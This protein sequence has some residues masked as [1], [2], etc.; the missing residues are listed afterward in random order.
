MRNAPS[1]AFAIAKTVVGTQRLFRQLNLMMK[2]TFR[3]MISMEHLLRC[4]KMVSF[5]ILLEMDMMLQLDIRKSDMDGHISMLTAHQ[6]TKQKES[7]IFTVLVSAAQNP[8]K[9]KQRKNI[10]SQTL[11]RTTAIS[12]QALICQICQSL[13]RMRP[14]EKP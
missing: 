5:Y 9:T 3:M 8:L 11:S 6:P 13:K 4:T 7:C 10:T 1:N 12:S 14:T 2:Q